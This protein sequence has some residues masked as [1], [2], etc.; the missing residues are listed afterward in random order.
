M[1]GAIGLAVLGGLGL[2]IY[3]VM[4][5]FAVDPDTTQAVLD[6]LFNPE[7]KPDA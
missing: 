4:I 3:F 5:G 6:A 7:T 1:L 2:A